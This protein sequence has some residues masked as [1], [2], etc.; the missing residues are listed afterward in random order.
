MKVVEIVDWREFHE[1]IEG[2]DG[3]GRIFRGVASAEYGLVP[4][5]GRAEFNKCYSLNAEKLLLDIFKQ[6]AVAHV[7]FAPSCEIEWLALAQHHGL[8]TRLLD[9]T[10]NPLVALFFAALSQ[11]DADG[12]VYTRHLR[13]D[14]PAE[15]DQK[16]KPFDVRR[17]Y[18]Y[19]PPHVTS[20]ITVQH[21]LFTIQP[22]PVIPMDHPRLLKI[23]IPR[24]LKVDFRKRLYSYGINQETMFPDLDGICGHL[25][26]RFREGIGHWPK[27]R[28][29]KRIVTR[30]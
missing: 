25:A 9:W 24:R 10:V 19:Y 12:A 28:S 2:L 1:V 8:P 6:R 27:R 17:V 11:S 23:V 14:N 20:R 22:D 15:F 18:K 5:V 7:A 29:G 21:A 3:A 16:F 26:W 13:R 4:K 30:P